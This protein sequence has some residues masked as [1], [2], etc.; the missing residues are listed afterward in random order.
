MT[1]V[2]GNP[3]PMRTISELKQRVTN[4]ERRL[5]N[6]IRQRLD[7]GTTWYMHELELTEWGPWRCP[8]RRRLSSIQAELLVPGSTTTTVHLNLN[9]TSLGS[10]SLA[11]GDDFDIEPLSRQLN[12][13]QDILT[14]ETT[15]LGTGASGLR[16]TARFAP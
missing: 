13:D 11:S 16:L 7:L 2:I 3:D 14:A 8:D 5:D 1:R 9:G 4:L 12:P 15:S 10:V 6:E